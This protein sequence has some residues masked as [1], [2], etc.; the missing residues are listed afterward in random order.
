MFYRMRCDFN[1]IATWSR[2]VPPAKSICKCRILFKVVGARMKDTVDSISD[3]LYLSLYKIVHS[4]EYLHLGVSQTRPTF[5]TCQT[6]FPQIG[7]V[8]VHAICSTACG[9]GKE[10]SSDDR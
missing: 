1:T 2:T 10:S 4:V 8:D 9:T 7:H 5:G 6:E 3:F